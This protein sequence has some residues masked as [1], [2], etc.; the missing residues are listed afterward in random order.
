MSHKN[1]T[2]QQFRDYPVRARRYRV[3]GRWFDL[4]GPADH[5]SLLDEPRIAERFAHDEY[6]PYWAEIWPAALLLADAVAA[7]GPPKRDP[8]AVLDL[9]CGL[10]LTALVATRLGYRVIAA[11]YDDDALAFVRAN[12]TRNDLPPPETLLIDWR[13]TYPYLSADRIVAADVLYETRSLRPVAEFVAA[14][15]APGGLALI[16]D[17]NRSTAEAFDT[18]ARHCGLT[19]EIMPVTR[20]TSEASDRPIAGRLFQIRHKQAE[21]NLLQESGL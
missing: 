1:D 2:P 6:I 7:W 12:A 11:D 21:H 3:A 5:E 9:G 10:G 15:L 16:A 19:V 20:P 17:P 4:L 14:H 18:I 13:E 8:P